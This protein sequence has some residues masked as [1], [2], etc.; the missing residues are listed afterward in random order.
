MEEARVLC[1]PYV[2]KIRFY[3]V[4]TSFHS[5]VFRLLYGIKQT[6]LP[7]KCFSFSFVEW[8]ELGN[9]LLLFG[10]DQRLPGKRWVK[11]FCFDIVVFICLNQKKMEFT[12]P[13][14]LK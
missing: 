11:L 3:L 9:W 7:R 13:L 14:W 1:S 10:S 2:V 8:I 4:K 12:S 5:V 6:Y